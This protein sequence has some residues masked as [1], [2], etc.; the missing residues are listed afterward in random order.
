MAQR[1]AD[2]RVAARVERAEQDEADRS[3]SVIR[4]DHRGAVERHEAANADRE[5]R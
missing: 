1:G 2:A 3:H 5:N 4:G